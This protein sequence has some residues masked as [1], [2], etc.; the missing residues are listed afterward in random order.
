MQGFLRLEGL[1]FY[2]PPLLLTV[3]GF[4]IGWWPLGV[5]FLGLTLFLMWFFRDPERTPQGD[6]VIS[7]ADGTV[8]RVVDLE[9]GGK[10]VDIFMSVVNVHV[11]RAPVAGT[12]GGI[13]YTPG[14]KAPAG[15]EEAHRFN[16]NNYFEVRGDGLTVGARQIAGILARRIVFWKRDGDRV[17]RGQRVGM[18]KFGSRV[19]VTLP[20]GLTV[21][22]NQGDKV[23]AGSTVLAQA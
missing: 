5:L 12:I 20:P 13:L 9:G 11:N 16:E 1:P 17:E 19:E 4:V 15:S 21:N 3:A 2:G 6:G 14:R 10:R 7:P 23:R 22:V 18:I 8:L